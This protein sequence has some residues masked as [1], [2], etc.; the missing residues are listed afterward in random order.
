MLEQR[1]KICYCV[2]SNEKSLLFARLRKESNNELAIVKDE[3][4]GEERERKI[5]SDEI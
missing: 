4:E 5:K 3:I 2:L 1:K